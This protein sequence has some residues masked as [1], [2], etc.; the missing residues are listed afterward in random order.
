VVVQF[1]A[2]CRPPVPAQTTIWYAVL[3]NQV[4]HETASRSKY[5]KVSEDHVTFDRP[6]HDDRQRFS[7]AGGRRF[8]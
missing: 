7:I 3:R 6:F 8:L 5:A 1:S 4:G 2:E